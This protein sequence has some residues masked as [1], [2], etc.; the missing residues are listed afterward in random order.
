MF[1]Y[2][3]L[4]FIMATDDSAES[5]LPPTL[6]TPPKTIFESSTNLDVQL[7]VYKLLRENERSLSERAAWEKARKIIGNG[8]AVLR[9]KKEDWV[10]QLGIYGGIV[11]REIESQKYINVK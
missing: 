1:G 2:S 11:F 8:R 5:Q 3:Q 4:V 10:E 6:S 9:F 7:Y